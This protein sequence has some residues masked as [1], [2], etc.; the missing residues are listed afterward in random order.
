MIRNSGFLILILMI[1]VQAV[2]QI[3]AVSPPPPQGSQASSL[4]ISGRNVQNGSVT[5]TES[6]VPGTTT[7]VNT[8]NPSVQVQGP[9]AGSIESRP[10]FSGRLSLRE[11]VERGLR[12]NLGAIDLSQ[13]VRQAGGQ[14]KVARSALLPTVN[15]FLSESV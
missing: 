3:G 6:P 4:P 7:S 12:Y 15:G 1:A 8:I 10:P 2:A 14:S 13:T 9:Y 11:A 5:A